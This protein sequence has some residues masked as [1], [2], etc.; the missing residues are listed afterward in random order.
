MLR[1][2]RPLLTAAL[3]V[4]SV[5]S[6]P[7]LTHAAPKV[8]LFGNG[9]EPQDLDPQIITG[10]PEH[11]LVDAL[12][13]GLVM[14]APEGDEPAPGVAERWE[15]STDG[16]TYTFHLRA[17][18]KWSNGDP[19]TA[20][21]FVR[22]Y[23]RM[24]TPALGAD[25]AYMLFLAAGAE[26]FFKG[27]IIDFAQ[28]GFRAVDAHT[29][30]IVLRQPAP[31]FV[32]S[33]VHPAWFPVHIP[34]VEKAGGLARKGTAW[35]RP[36]NFVG[37][38]AFVL[39]E[40][41]PGQR[42]VAKRSPT[43]WDHARVKLDEIQFHPVELSDTEERMFRTGQLHITNEVPLT[44]IAVYEREQP[45]HIRTAPWCGVYYYRFNV[46]R[47]PFDD[48]RVR[49]A[50]A[51]AIDRETLVKFV[52]RAGEK[53]AYHVVPP[54][55][56]GFTSQHRISGDI[57]EARRLLAEAGYPGGKGFPKVELLY[58]TLEKHKLIAEALQQMWRKNLGIGITLYNQEWKVYLDAQKSGNFQFQRAGW[59]ADYVDPH[60]FLDLWRTGG[61]NNNTQW[62]SAH[63]DR[64]LASSLDA[65]T[66]DARF[67]IYQEME[68]IL[69]DELPVLPLYFYTRT[70]LISPKVLNFQITNLDS[71]PWKYVDLAE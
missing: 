25:Y 3:L 8:L 14:P 35:T 61:G 65:K 29:L 60:V 2:F 44:K 9:T 43:Y 32:R 21:D 48:V 24:L 22:T 39:A 59:I 56:G 16:L 33:L 34:T 47:K 53:P 20:H 26:D 37:N 18:A 13:E 6:F 45:T 23:Q 67:A 27:Q 4:S 57:A 11:R 58:N 68:K 30:Q 12:F 64:L 71:Y 5:T 54:G 63:Y 41:K 55:V 69:V 1:L 50:L 15:I 17:D 66:Q 62:G 42:I 46:T 28:T 19:V 36:E 40:W 70:R 51:L 38:G 10:V 52:T 31:F 7:L 49:R